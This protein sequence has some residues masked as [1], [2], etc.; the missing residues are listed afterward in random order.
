MKMA[1]AT[2]S[3]W[4]DCG[5]TEGTLEV[6]SKTS[7]LPS[8][9]Y[10]YILPSI[11]RESLFSQFKVKAPYEDLYDCS[12]LQMSLDMNNGND[13]EVYGWIDDVS[14][15]SDTAGYPVTVVSWHIDFWRTYLPRVSVG[16][17][18][19][20]RRPATGTVPPQDHSFMYRTPTSPQD[21]YTTSDDDI[22]WVM[23]N[24]TSGENYKVVN[25]ITYPVSVS[26][27]LTSLGIDNSS[28]DSGEPTGYCPS[29]N[30]TMFG[31]FDELLQL[32]PTAIYGAWISPVPPVSYSKR[33]YIATR[34]F[35]CDWPV[36]TLGEK[37]V[38]RAYSTDSYVCPY[39]EFYR[40]VDATTTDT[41]EFVVTDQDCAPVGTL[42]WGLHFTS[43]SVRVVNCDISA[44]LSIRFKTATS[45]YEEAPS[46][47]AEFNIPLKNIPLTSNA[48]SSY[49]FSGQEQYDRTQL[50]I[51]REQSLV[52]SVTGGADSVLSNVVMSS[53]GNTTT[54][55]ADYSY[56]LRSLGVNNKYGIEAMEVAPTMSKMVVQQAASIPVPH[57]LAA[58]MGVNLGMAAANYAL[59][60]YFNDKAMDNTISYKKSQTSSMALPSSGLDWTKF[61]RALSLISLVW[62]D[63]SKEQRASDLELY[64]ARVCEPREDCQS[65]V[66]AGGPLRI[67][68]AVVTGSV[69]TP[70]K[71]FIRKRFDAGVRMI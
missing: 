7:S 42:P 6:P 5:F 14:C 59:G 30:Q 56:P 25:T 44:Y 17:G 63:Y 45:T 58:G 20:L 71:D 33:A 29:F 12:Y 8:S 31:E 23:V 55:K 47:G 70:A 13:V 27:P 9:D 53:L 35:S 28:T 32:D 34:C 22:Y 50:Q 39:D 37:K 49:R 16:R 3:V 57:V 52:S 67:S 2:V 1:S 36:A 43:C 69:P 15:S 66:D 64:G 4:R 65:L 61:G 62:D 68:D 10:T 40:L 46:L 38:F 54:T 19:V 18:T 48:Y 21:L 51:Q 24:Y 60:G 11:P 41:E 26:N